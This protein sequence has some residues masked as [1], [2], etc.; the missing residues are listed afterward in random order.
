[1][2]L[3]STIS[4]TRSSQLGYLDLHL[5][6]SAPTHRE[7]ISNLL[8][9]STD[10]NLLIAEPLSCIRY[11][12]PY[13][14]FNIKFL[15]CF[16]MLHFY[17]IDI[18]WWN[19]STKSHIVS[20]TIRLLLLWWVF[21]VF[22]PKISDFTLWVII[23]DIVQSTKIEFSVYLFRK[24]N[25]FLRYC[26]LCKNVLNFLEK[27]KFLIR[28]LSFLGSLISYCMIRKLMSIFNIIINRIQ[29]CI[30]GIPNDTLDHL[31]EAINKIR[32]E[33]ITLFLSISTSRPGV[34]RDDSLTWT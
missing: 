22:F 25:R 7:N 6:S 17:L 23:R 12:F 29:F 14:R 27:S 18:P 1:M 15:S 2:L 31:G 24:L 16:E 34:V 28:K 33:V 32:S 9:S 5:S 20:W 26:T 30:G 3:V 21:F 13:M 19:K 11:N 8:I 10:P 4:V